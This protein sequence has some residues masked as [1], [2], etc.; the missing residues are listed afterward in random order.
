MCLPR[1]LTLSLGCTLCLGLCLRSGHAE[2]EPA[3]WNVDFKGTAEAEALIFSQ[4]PSDPRQRDAAVAGALKLDLDWTHP[5][6][7][8]RFKLNT[9]ARVDS[10]DSN[11][12]RVD[13]REANVYWDFGDSDLLLGATTVFWGTTE[14]V[15]WA[16]VINQTN[17]PEDPKLESKLG[18]PLLNYNRYTD[19]GTF[20]LYVMPYFRERPFPGAHG[21]LRSIPR[22]IE[23]TATYES[24]R[25]EWQTDL[26]LRWEHYLGPLEFGLGYFYG[27][28][29]EP[30]FR[31]RLRPDG[32]LVLDPHYNIVHQPSIDGVW[33]FDQW[34][35]KFEG[36]ARFGQDGGDFYRV[37]I[38]PEYTAYGIGGSRADLDL[39]SE[40]LY[41][42]QGV[43]PINPYERDL[44][45]GFRVRFNDLASSRIQLTAINDLDGDGHVLNLEASRRFKENWMLR[46]EAFAFLDID[47]EVF[48]LNGFRRDDHLR[49]TCEYRF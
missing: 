23:G 27:T 25:E 6:R 5:D 28:V 29:R 1:L 47:P 46:L 8:Y 11:R 3:A 22:V 35:L 2:A 10:A 34:L 33:I 36:M 31:P 17:P 21:R 39:F 45:V 42:S 38:G 7:D 30:V 40:F 41:D 14:T 13:L 48:P 24:S 16:D 12:D 19:H 32:E 18:Q 44:A 9:F 15:H 4:N 26:A 37:A 20:G 49:I 43:N